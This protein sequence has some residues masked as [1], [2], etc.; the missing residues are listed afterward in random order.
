MMPDK[1]VATM[2]YSHTL[3]EV[4][5]II[6]RYLTPWLESGLGPGT[7]DPPLRTLEQYVVTYMDESMI[8][9]YQTAKDKLQTEELERMKKMEHI[10]DLIKASIRDRMPLFQRRIE[11]LEMIMGGDAGDSDEREDKLQAFVKRIITKSEI[12]E[13]DK[14]DTDEVRKLILVTS[15]RS[16]DL[17]KELLE[18]EERRARGGSDPMSFNQV[19]DAVSKYVYQAQAIKNLDRKR[20]KGMPRTKEEKKKD[21]DGTVTLRRVES[22]DGKCYKCGEKGHFARDCTAKMECGTC[23]SDRHTTETGQEQN[24]E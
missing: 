4:E 8:L 18:E 7:E 13:L 16:L 2:K 21:D 6:A 9:R 10:F 19:I 24:K 20:K 5:R 3:E 17:R 1:A 23:H 11:V 12:A 15:L 22:M 14:L